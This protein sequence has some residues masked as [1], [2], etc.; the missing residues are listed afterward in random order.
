MTSPSCLENETVA[1]FIRDAITAIRNNNKRPEGQSVFDYINKSS[2]TK[3]DQKY[4]TSV[5]KDMLDK[6]LIYD[7]PSKKGS[8]YFITELTN[9]NSGEKVS[10]LATT[11]H[12]GFTNNEKNPVD[13]TVP[14]LSGNLTTPQI[15]I[16]NVTKKEPKTQQPKVLVST[17]LHFNSSLRNHSEWGEFEI[18][19]DSVF[20]MKAELLKVNNLLR[21]KRHFNTQRK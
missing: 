8:S 9:N 17:N 3:M 12:S 4:I 10:T 1:Q 20:N 6:N 18:L 13:P 15:H 14:Y 7:K 21:S 5:I 16:E 19:D 11:E 2:E